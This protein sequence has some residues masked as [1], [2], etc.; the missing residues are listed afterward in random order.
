MARSDCRTRPRHL[1]A[2]PDAAPA[3]LPEADITVTVDR[4]RDLEIST[5]SRNCETTVQLSGELDF[6]NAGLLRSVVDTQV[7][8]GYREMRLD[9]SLLTFCDCTGLRAVVHA[10]NV[11]R[12]LSGRLV[13]SGV[14]PSVDKLLTLTRLDEALDL[15]RSEQ[16]TARPALTMVGSEARV[17]GPR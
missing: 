11:L 17:A 9:L 16:P 15:E 3:Q 6:S 5:I 2:V 4:T 8:H 1:W 13:I 7:R 12:S 14:G 10:H